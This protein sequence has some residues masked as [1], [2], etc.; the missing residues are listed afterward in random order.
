M[1]IIMVTWRWTGQPARV[2]ARSLIPCIDQFTISTSW[3]DVCCV[4]DAADA[5]YFVG[6]SPKVP[7]Q[8]NLGSAISSAA[9]L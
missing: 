7:R 5:G 3:L 6:L 8:R 1:V 2:R 4:I 9:A